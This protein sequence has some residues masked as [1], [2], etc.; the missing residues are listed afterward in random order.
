MI[1]LD[2]SNNDNDDHIPETSYSIEQKITILS[3]DKKW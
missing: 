2:N 3:L 1:I